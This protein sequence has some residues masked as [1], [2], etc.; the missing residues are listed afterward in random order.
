MS[1]TTSTL[2]CGKVLHPVRELGFSSVNTAHSNY[3][4]PSK[5]SVMISVVEC[6]TE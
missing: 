3:P 4:F 1:S 2:A 6:R 5:H